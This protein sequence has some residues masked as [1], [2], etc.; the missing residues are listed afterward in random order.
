MPT[1]PR[2]LGIVLGGG[3]ARG[4]FHAGALQELFTNQVTDG[5]KKYPRIDFRRVGVV[6]GTSTG[7]LCASMLVQFLARNHDKAPGDALDTRDLDTLLNIYRNTTTAGVMT[8]RLDAGWANAINAVAALLGA[9][10]LPADKVVAL[11]VGVSIFD[12]AP[13]RALIRQH[14]DLTVQKQAA[15]LGIQLVINTYN[16]TTL[17]GERFTNSAADRALLHDAVIASAAIPAV[18]TPHHITRGGVKSLYV[19]GAIAAPVPY[20]PAVKAGISRILAISLNYLGTRSGKTDYAVGLEVL[21]DAA[22][23]ADQEVSDGGELLAK[24]SEAIGMM[25]ANCLAAGVDF[26]TVVKGVDAQVL[27]ANPSGAVRREFT[28]HI[29]LGTPLIEDVDFDPAKMQTLSVAGQ[30]AARG[31]WANIRAALELPSRASP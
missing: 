13:L 8:P 22:Y 9:G 14:V 6:S 10:G 25:R 3:G 16:M 26:A 15:D 27:T 17:R 7:A 30:T 12:Q 5:P 24:Y 1:L 31:Q 23:A 4:A 11:V 29:P 2:N 19:D 20:A 28:L 21:K 18:M